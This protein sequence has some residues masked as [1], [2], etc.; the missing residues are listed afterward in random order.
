[1]RGQR[2]H[3]RRRG[4]NSFEIKFSTGIGA[5]R[6]THYLSIKGSR[7]DAQARLTQELARVGEGSFATPSK[8]TVGDFA[9]KRV[10]AWA[11]G[12]E[13]TGRTAT[14]YHQ[15]LKYQIEPHLGGTL[16]QKLGVIALR[17]WHGKLRQQGL[18]VRTI[19]QVHRLLHKVLAEAER[20]GM[21]TKNVARLQH[22]PKR[23]VDEIEE[24][25]IVRDVPGLLAK[26][27]GDPL[28][29][30]LAVLGVY[31]GLRLGEVLALRWGRVHLDQQPRIE[32][33]EARDGAN[34]KK[35]KSRAGERTISLPAIVVETLRAH[36]VAQMELRL[37]MGAGRLGDA[38]FLFQRLD[39][40][41]F[42]VTSVS[43][44]WARTMDQIGMGEITYHALRHTHAS[45]LI[46]AGLPIT[47]ISK[48]LGHSSP[49]ITLSVYAHCFRDDDRAAAAAID[50][51]LKG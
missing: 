3:I 47:V 9:R 29:Y 31:C 49:A 14:R 51:A 41:P 40:R 1:M 10:A 11:D 33:V 23:N 42:L 30:P 28:Y 37:K 18:A 15:I 36:R 5:E 26:L 35:P 44:D 2:G 34:F 43:R 17:D 6:K 7:A 20:D 27:A 13:I 38:D 8:V 21:I 19:R 24:I 4:K 22:A 12:G 50:A 39:G 45:Q 32:I 16:L 25:T 48:R 46:D